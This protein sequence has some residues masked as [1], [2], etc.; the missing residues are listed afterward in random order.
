MSEDTEPTV[1]DYIR[2]LAGEEPK[3]KPEP[4]AEEQEAAAPSTDGED[5]ATEEEETSA[6]EGETSEDQEASDDNEESEDD[7]EDKPKRR[8]SRPDPKK[9]IRKLVAERNA[10]RDE[11]ARLRAQIDLLLK[12]SQAQPVQAAD[13]TQAQPQSDDPQPKQDQYDDYAKY[14]EDRSAWASRQAVKE[15]LAEA[16]KQATQAQQQQTAATRETELVTQAKALFDKGTEEFD[17]FEEVAADPELPVTEAM[18]AA[19]LAS[20]IGHQVQY[21]LGSHPDEAARIAKLNPVQQVREM[22]L[23]EASLS[24]PKAKP[25]KKTTSAPEPIKPVGGKSAPKSIDEDDISMDD[26]MKMWI[27][28]DLPSQKGRVG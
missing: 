2:E 24:A 9:R 12:Q 19:M 28:G 16:Q 15:A 21:H 11:T 6:D 14:I 10:E 26:Y 18:T 7:E 3:P 1:E 20:D 27:H 22:A 13:Q 25:K 23:L 5:E 4:K 17:D 8:R